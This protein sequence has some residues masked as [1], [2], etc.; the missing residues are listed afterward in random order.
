MSNYCEKCT[1]DPSEMTG[2]NACPFN[3]LY[4]DFFV[5]HEDRFRGNQRMPYVFSNW[6]KFEPDK[7]K[8]IRNRAAANLQKMSEGRL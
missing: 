8:A 5:R 3:A 2:E 1:Y 4:W 6:D 7:Q